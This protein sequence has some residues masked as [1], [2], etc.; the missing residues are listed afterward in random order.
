MNWTV[1]K[2]ELQYRHNF[3]IVKEIKDS[4]GVQ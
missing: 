2:G 1:I 4:G 3:I